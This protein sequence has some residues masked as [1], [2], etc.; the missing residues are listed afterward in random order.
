MVMLVFPIVL[1]C[2]QWKNNEHMKN[3]IPFGDFQQ[4]PFSTFCYII[5]QPTSKLAMT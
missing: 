4:S 3:A 1:W 2:Y 5:D